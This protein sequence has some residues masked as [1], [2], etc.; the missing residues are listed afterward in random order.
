MSD[1]KTK[2]EN[3]SKVIESNWQRVRESTL[4]KKSGKAIKR[5]C[6]RIGKNETGFVELDLD[7]KGDGPHMLVAGTTGSGKTETMITYLLGLCMNCGPDELNL[8]L[9]D[10]KGGGFTKRIGN[11]PHVVGQITDVAG[12]ENGTGAEYMLR[13]FLQAMA[14]EIK[15]RKVLFNRLHVDSIDDYIKRYREIERIGV[16]KYAEEKHIE[17]GFDFNSIQDISP[18]PHLI[19]VVDEFTELKRFSS[20]SSDV[21]FISEITTIARVGRSLG[22]HIVLISQNIEGAI[23]D[24]IRVN[25]N[26]RLCHKVATA[27]A[28][29]EMIGSA[30]AASP[31]MPGNGRAYLQSGNGKR[32]EYFQA[33]YSKMDTD[34]VVPMKIEL[35]NKTGAYELFYNSEEDNASEID[36]KEQRE[37]AGEYLT[38]L[39]LITSAICMAYEREKNNYSKHEIFKQ[40]LQRKIT[41]DDL[42]SMMLIKEKEQLKKYGKEASDI[43]LGQYD[44][45]ESQEQPLFTYN[46]VKENMIIFGGTGSGKTVLVKSMLMQMHEK[47]L[48]EE[49]YIIDFGGSIGEYRELKYVYGCF[50]NSN[51]ENVKRVFQ[52]VHR[53]FEENAKSLGSDSYISRYEKEANSCP[54]HVTLIIENANAFLED[55]RYSNYREELAFLCRDGR[56]K[57][58]SVVLTAKEVS[59]LSK[60]MIHFNKRV[61]FEM[62]SDNYWDIFNAKLLK[63]I[64]N[65]GRGLAD[66]GNVVREVQVAMYPEKKE[67]ELLF[68]EYCGVPEGRIRGFHED[69]FVYNVNTDTR[70]AIVVG[71]EYYEQKEVEIDF[72]SNPCIAIYG[73]RKFG[74]TNLLQLLLTQIEKKDSKRKW[75]YI[76][77]DDGR[78]QLDENH[79]KVFYD[80]C[81]KRQKDLIFYFK[82]GIN[83]FE[84]KEISHDEPKV[85]VLQA[86]GFYNR[87]HNS[88]VSKK[89]VDWVEKE[90][91]LGQDILIFSDVKRTSSSLV[92]DEMKTWFQ[93][94]FLLDNIGDFVADRGS[95]S[96]FGEMDAKEL[97]T[98]YANCNLGDGYFYDVDTD[99]L[100]KLR[101]YKCEGGE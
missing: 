93:Y 76:L 43:V 48:D 9:V 12:D 38:Q 73:K 72:T 100:K 11:L 83:F 35:A 7:E 57:G 82:E 92:Q 15:S 23:T 22:F 101:F 94:A 77:L 5:L 33:G 84:D 45:P 58:V 99:E 69:E 47:N 51:E 87:R 1:R 49:V 97:K 79:L 62:P 86:R 68:G 17:G 28:S 55:E 10:M 18:L 59:G 65:Q 90:L 42:E 36:S 14:A 27:Q 2:I 81:E 64:N 67:Q 53:R 20:Q 32:L 75:Q 54:R 95:G 98:E 66:C 19:L 70:S 78:G 26:A 30:L 16:K 24:D 29:K 91:E 85:I 96:V 13:R 80:L 21:D 34:E 71:K 31:S 4:E 41:Y 25:S 60:I 3:V 46:H 8:L 44:D 39:E 6:A 56:S 89:F 40:P 37:R 74:K 61:A 50:D 52:T 88:D 63:P